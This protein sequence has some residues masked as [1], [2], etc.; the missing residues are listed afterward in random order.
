MG[1][2]PGASGASASPSSLRR[3][4]KESP[5]RWITLRLRC[6]APSLLP[7]AVASPCQ[8]SASLLF[9]STLLGLLL[10][11]QGCLKGSHA[12]ARDCCASMLV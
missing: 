5:R 3:L 7:H 8:H 10:C 2:G 9:Y 12:Q 11:L 4:L 6:S 1:R